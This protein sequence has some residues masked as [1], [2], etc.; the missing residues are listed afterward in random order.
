MADAALVLV[1]ESDP[2]VLREIETILRRAGHEVAAA[3]DGALA[4]NRALAAPPQL[5]VAAAEMPLVD[6][7]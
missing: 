7:F 5:I 1:A 4:M 6:G 2:E 3:T